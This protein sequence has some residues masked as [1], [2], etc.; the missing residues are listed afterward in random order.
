MWT[1]EQI[2]VWVGCYDNHTV[3]NIWSYDIII[4]EIDESWSLFCSLAYSFILN[5]LVK[6]RLDNARKYVL[7]KKKHVIHTTCAVDMKCFLS[8]AHQLLIL[9]MKKMT[10]SK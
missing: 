4:V 2:I 10:N 7:I 5:I 8:Y 9:N 1:L 3:T 6:V